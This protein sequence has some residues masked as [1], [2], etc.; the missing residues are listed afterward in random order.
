MIV[1]PQEDVVCVSRTRNLVKLDGKS[2]A[3]LCILGK[4]ILGTILSEPARKCAEGIYRISGCY[5]CF[6]VIGEKLGVQ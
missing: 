3:V 6:T 1:F 5:V 2:V 4:V